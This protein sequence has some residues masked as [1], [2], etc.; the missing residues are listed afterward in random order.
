M[1]LRVYNLA[2]GDKVLEKTMVNG[3][4]AGLPLGLIYSGS[5]AVAASYGGEF[6]F[7]YGLLSSV[8]FADSSGFGGVLF[9]AR[10]DGFDPSTNV[11]TGEYGAIGGFGLVGYYATLSTN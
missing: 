1:I 6:I 8:S 3:G 5:G 7:P 9:R 4:D 10:P 2:S 11:N